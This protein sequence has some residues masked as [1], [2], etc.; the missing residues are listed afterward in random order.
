[1]AKTLQTDPSAYP[2]AQWHA[3]LEAAL[4]SAPA[5]SSDIERLIAGLDASALADTL[6]SLEPG[7][8]RAL[9]QELAPERR[10]AVLIEVHGEVRRQLIAWTDADDLLR[11][12]APLDLD[13]LT[14]LDDELPPPVL[15]G[16]VAG[17]DAQRRRRYERLRIH[18][19]DSAGGLMDADPIVVRP[20]DTAAEAVQALR[21]HRELQGGLPEH[22]HALMVTDAAGA[23]LGTIDL[24]E[25]LLHDGNRPVRDIMATDAI[26]IAASLPAADVAQ[27][28]EDH[29]LLSAAVVDE[30]GRLIGRVTVDDVV[31]VIRAQAERSLLANTG[32]DE[33]TDTFAP[34]LEAS[35]RRALWL[36]INLA[37]ALIA[38]A[39]IGLFEDTIGH[40]V[41][42]AVLMPVV[43][44]MGGVAGTQS[45]ALVIRAMALHQVQPGT[46]WRLLR[47]E[48]GVAGV[49]G[50][51]WALVVAA[52]A[53]AWFGSAALAAVFAAAVLLNLMLGVLAGTTIPML[54]T[55][56][57]IDP[58]LAGGVVLVAATD[59]IGFGLFLG[60]GHV[61]LT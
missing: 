51:L 45:L 34:T 15:A 3:A 55:R 56:L 36:G 16:V 41:A 29:D 28:F 40:L 35:K 10:G 8:R 13:A 39:V 22:L 7:L 49:N 43:A 11:A 47:R 19:D 53:M 27:L 24:A 48:L 61:V 60:L 30:A 2:G 59:A 25:L 38:A 17:M 58:A 20:E 26:A 42:L 37:N 57:R 9:W 12:V 21:R 33:N 31:D 32:M 4:E 14:D 54:L 52:V 46:R 23:F 1:M 18:P 5:A 50:L 6:E 44:S